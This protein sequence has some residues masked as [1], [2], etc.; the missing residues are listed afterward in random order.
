MRHVTVVV[1]L[2]SRGLEGEP[3]CTSH[4]C[5]GRG[6]KG[7]R[8]AHNLFLLPIA[9]RPLWVAPRLAPPSPTQVGTAITTITNTTR[10]RNEVLRA[11]DTRLRALETRLGL[12]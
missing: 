7:A 12:L 10:E 3:A 6:H 8:A 9:P 2:E 1:Q 11:E 4:C 5:C